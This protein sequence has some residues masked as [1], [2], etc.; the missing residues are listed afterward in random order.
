[1]KMWE[2]LFNLFIIVVAVFFA[3]VGTIDA[4]MKLLEDDDEVIEGNLEL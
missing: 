1:M 2:L 3:F 4:I